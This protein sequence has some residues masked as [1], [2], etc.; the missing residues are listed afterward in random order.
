MTAALTPED[1]SRFAA[2]TSFAL[3]PD[4]ARVVY[5]LLTVDAESDKRRSTLWLLDLRQ[6]DS[7]PRRLTNGAQR[8]HSPQWSPDGAWIAFVSDRAETAQLWV[9][10][11]AGGEPSQLTHMRYG[12]NSPRW[13]PDGQSLLFLAEVRGDED[14]FWPTPDDAVARERRERHEANRLRHITRLQFRW[15]GDDISEGRQHIWRMA[16]DAAAL[17]QGTSAP[18]PERVTSGD[19]DHLDPAWSPDGQQIAFVSD[20][21]EDR[22]ANRTDDVWV[23]DLASGVVTRVTNHLCENHTPVWG[24]QGQLAWFCA[25]VV[26]GI[27]Y[28]NTHVWLAELAGDGWHTWDAMDGHDVLAGAGISSDVAVVPSGPPTWSADGQA[29]FVT[30]HARGVTNLHRLDR[31][32]GTLT[33]LSQG[34]WQFGPIAVAP[35]E[36]LIALAGTPERPIDLVRCA[37]RGAQ[38]SP[39]WLTEVNPWLREQTLAMPEVFTFT[40]ADGWELEG[41]VMWPPE[42]VAGVPV[43]AILQIHGGPHGSFG[44]GFHAQRQQFTGAGYAVVIVNPRG[45][46]GYGE[47][48][49]RACD[50][51][52]GGADYHDIM[53]GLDAALA[54]GG[55]DAARLA[56]TGVSY[57]G[58]MTNWIVGHTDRF[59]AAVT[60][61]SVSNLISSFGT[62]DIDAVFGVV[63]QGGTPWERRDWYLERSPVTYADRVT[64]PTRVISAER[65]WRCPIEQSEQFYMALRYFNRAPTDFLRVPGASHSIR[66]GTPSQHV[67]WCRAVLDWIVQYNPVSE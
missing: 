10:P 6:P 62:S 54:R 61:N 45:S 59:K 30:V 51:D 9:L 67:T 49:A 1:I 17:G 58:Y 47:T 56:V 7:P 35:D 37:A 19:Y 15:D 12:A 34:A 36:S 63:E 55:I 38:A 5:A 50:R 16:F 57:G 27:S 8:D 24:P 64:T 42:W 32:A 31:V 22:D 46:V 53:A 43:P 13:S 21:A 40:T 18:T 23:Q 39:I 11:T 60:I 25:N 44:P 3:S 14:P 29:L 65:D 4:G 20:R 26:T 33:A 52:W 48:F 28:S 66:T 2:P 41:W